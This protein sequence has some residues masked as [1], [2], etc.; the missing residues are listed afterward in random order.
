MQSTAAT[1]AVLG[2]I[3]LKPRS[4]YDIKRIVDGSIR[5]F[6]AASPGQIYPEL[7]R[8]E[9]AGWIEG[10]DVP[11]GG[12]PRRVYRISEAGSAA[13]QGWL[14]GYETRVELRDESLLRIFFSDAAPHE[15]G[16]GLIAAR[17][18]GYRQMLAHLESLDDGTGPDPPFVDVVY[19]WGLDH[20]RWGIEWCDAQLER[21]QR[22][23]AA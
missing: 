1:W 16:L 12:R 18:E 14:A 10:D 7:K 2:L 8:L 23:E 15:H 6:W 21:L 5:H 4:G 3:G 9:R 13:L 11:R 22:E 19:R 20:C 17:R